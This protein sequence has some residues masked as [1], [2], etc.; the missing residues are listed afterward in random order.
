MGPII[1]VELEMRFFGPKFLNKNLVLTRRLSQLLK[2]P[3]EVVRQ[4]NNCLIASYEF[5]GVVQS[6]FVLNKINFS[7]LLTFLGKEKIS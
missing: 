2:I 4:A 3:G 7:L 6:G 5:L 1:F